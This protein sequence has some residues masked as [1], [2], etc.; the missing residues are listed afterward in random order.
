MFYVKH[1]GTIDAQNQT[2]KPTPAASAMLLSELARQAKS[3]HA[4]R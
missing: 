4:P 1:F 3:P 2:K